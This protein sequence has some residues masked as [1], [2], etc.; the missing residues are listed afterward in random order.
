[1]ND[2]IIPDDIIKASTTDLID[3]IKMK[4]DF[5]EEAK[6]ALSILNMRF[7]ESLIKKAEVICSNWGYNEVIALDIVNCTF[8]RLWRYPSFKKEK[9]RDDNIDK[10]FKNWLFRIA[11]NELAKFHNQQRCDDRLDSEELEIINNIDELIDTV[12]TPLEKRK[13]L[14]KQFEILNKALS[15]LSEKHKIIYLT[16]KAYENNGKRTIPHAVTKKLREKLN[17]VQSTVKVYKNEAYE[18]VNDYLKTQRN[19]GGKN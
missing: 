5:P 16:Y 3:Y 17:I 2:Q 12:D 18:K 1:M 7:G 6:S 9:T 15:G 13:E 19:D 4:D 8:N 11:S 10:A 14:R